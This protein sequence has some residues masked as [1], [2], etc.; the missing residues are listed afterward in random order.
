MLK[1][2]KNIKIIQNTENKIVNMN[3]NKVGAAMLNMLALTAVDERKVHVFQTPLAG[4]AV[5][6]Q[7]NAWIA[8]AK[9]LVPKGMQETSEQV[10]GTII[11]D[12]MEDVEQ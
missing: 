9:L 10:F 12:K 3:V 11:V 1:T 8:I 4:V 2:I 5:E 7:G 6:H